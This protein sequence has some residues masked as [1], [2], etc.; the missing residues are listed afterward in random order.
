MAVTTAMSNPGSLGSQR[1]IARIA[2]SAAAPTATDVG[3][4]SP[5]A[6]P[7]TSSRIPPMTSSLSIGI[8]QILAAWPTTMSKAMPFR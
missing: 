8:S 7:A 2:T 3:F 6:R 1:R 5:A 4:A